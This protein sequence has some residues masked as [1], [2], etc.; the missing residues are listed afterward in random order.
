MSSA[1]LT[2]Q[3]ERGTAEA[4]TATGPDRDLSDA[5]ISGV[6]ALASL[7]GVLRRQDA[8]SPA[9]ALRDL[10]EMSIARGLHLLFFQNPGSD[11]TADLTDSALTEIVEK[12]SRELSAIACEELDFWSVRDDLSESHLRA[13]AYDL[14][15][16]AIMA[17][18]VCLL[19][20][21]L[22]LEP[23]EQE[24][25]IARML[26]RP[27]D[28]V[29]ARVEAAINFYAQNQRVRTARGRRLR[30]PV[31]PRLVLHAG[32]S[33][34]GSTYLQ[35]L[36]D[37]GRPALL[38]RGVW[39]PEVGLYRQ[40]PRPR[41]QAGHALFTDAAI[42]GGRN[43]RRHLRAGAGILGE[44]LHT[45]VLSSEAF[46]LHR[47]AHRIPRYLSDFDC[48]VVIYLRRQ[49]EWANSQYCELVAGGSAGRV[50][51]KISDWLS[52]DAV[53]EL[54]DYRNVL[55]RFA[56]V[57]PKETIKV[58]VYDPDALKEGDLVKDFADAADLPELLDLPRSTRSFGNAAVFSEAQIEIL[59]KLNASRFRGKEGYRE[60][61]AEVEDNLA[62]RRPP[63]GRAAM[64]LDGSERKA[65]L[66]DFSAANAEIARDWL[67]REDDALFSA[68]VDD[69]RSS[70][71]SPRGED[72]AIIY[73]AFLRWAKAS[74]AL[75]LSRLSGETDMAG[76]GTRIVNYGLFGWRLWALTPVVRFEVKRRGTRADLPA[77]DRDPSGF[78]ASL[79]SPRFKVWS[80]R[81]Y[82]D[83]PP[84]G[85]GGVLRIWIA[86]VA[87][88]IGLF[89]N[90]SAAE[91][92]RAD[93]VLFM[94]R[95]KNPAARV[96]GRIL[97]PMGEAVS[98][99]SER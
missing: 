10:A 66:R 87:T 11:E 22:N 72:V 32:I 94:R 3:N 14:M 90:Q 38:R 70:P 75:D 2:D 45:V 52:T 93:P 35:N 4:K 6:N 63:T 69:R 81:L 86:P 12:V 46:F 80:Q 21:A 74:P 41:K 92:F 20:R 18:N 85:P 51:D 31:R 8:L 28:E 78:F 58:R 99:D 1:P 26:A 97:F 67:G 50:S 15:L 95:L 61:I 77:F 79:E 40:G 88:A 7:V 29:E 60:F 5:S 98:D 33:K 68:N 24:E 49:D 27:A 39:Y 47:N 13:G 71:L 96:A 91:R 82:P 64:M 17:K 57:L 55:N 30:A 83:R 25:L 43:L 36:M 9:S 76:Q 59:R 56:R 48:E 73:R 65:L 89:G 44:R 62:A 42:G 34:T 54:M 19:R 84:L 23:F 37:A 16:A 53:R